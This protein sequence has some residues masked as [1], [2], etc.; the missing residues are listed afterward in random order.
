ME[1][2]IQPVS[3][4]VFVVKIDVNKFNNSKENSMLFTIICFLSEMA[5]KASLNFSIRRGFR[6]QYSHSKLKH[7]EG[8]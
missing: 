6:S 8:K 4:I 3:S 1:E 2:E 7:Y 5:I